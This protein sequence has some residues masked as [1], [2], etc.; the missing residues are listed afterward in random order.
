MIEKLLQGD[1]EGLRLF[2]VRM[3]FSQE[4]EQIGKFRLR[5]VAHL[6]GVI[7]RIVAIRVRH[8]PTVLYYPPAGPDRIPAYRD[9][10]V[11]LA[12]RWLY[13]KTVL[14][15]LAGGISELMPKLSV[16]GRTLFRRAYFDADCAIQLSEFTP[17]DGERLHAKHNVVVPLGVEDVYP[18]YRN[19]EE[20]DA[21]PPRLL[22]VGGVSA[23]KGVM[24]LLEACQRLHRDGH[25]FALDVMGRFQSSSF[26][27]AARRYVHENDLESKVTFLGVR[28]GDAKWQTF[29]RANVLCLPTYYPREAF[30]VVILEAMQFALPVVA[31]RWRGIPS[32]VSEAR[33]GYLIPTHD[34]KALGDRLALL[35]SDPALRRTMGDRARE[36]FLAEFTVGR[37]RER[38]EQ[39]LLLAT[40]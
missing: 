11:L 25:E 38:M 4:L 40:S 7:A 5:K 31:S 33:T 24:I 37:W 23:D 13:P 6:A 36:V 1:Y 3:D 32:L 12:T 18:E 14:H 28:D 15:F 34:P 9:I 8:H 21:G 2:H 39:A 19:P 20:R 22:F 17:P 26:E 16:V 10:C 29:T 27:T 35:L 30:P